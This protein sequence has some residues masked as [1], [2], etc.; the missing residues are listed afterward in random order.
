[1]RSSTGATNVVIH[2][3]HEC[4]RCDNTY[5]L[6][7]A[8]PQSPQTHRAGV[9]RSALALVAGPEPADVIGDGGRGVV[10]GLEAGVV[11]QT[12]DVEVD[13]AAEAVRIAAVAQRGARAGND[14]RDGGREFAVAGDPP[15]GHVVSAVA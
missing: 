11:T 13:V 10:T 8:L 6:L 7:W 4:G 14:V 5:I 15:G 1:M 9:R 3:G 12:R 2:R